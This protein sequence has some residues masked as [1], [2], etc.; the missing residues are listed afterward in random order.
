MDKMKEFFTEI[1]NDKRKRFIS[2]GIISGVVLIILIIIIAVAASGGSSSEDSKGKSSGG[3]SEDESASSEDY[4]KP[5]CS[6]ACSNPYNIKVYSDNKI[7]S[8]LIKCGYK[9]NTDLFN[10]VLEAT[11]RHNILRACHNAQPLLPNCEIMKISQDYAETLPYTHSGTKFHG[12]WMGENLFGSWGYNLNGAFPVNDWYNEISNYDF[13]TGTKKNSGDIGHFTQLVWK[14]SR[15]LGIGYYCQS[16]Q[17][18]V[19]GNYYP[20]GNIGGQYTSQ[21]QALQ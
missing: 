7:T 17:C 2:I 4:I 15:D 5:D 9:K 3:N 18:V 21:V 12:E 10:F 13:S 20:G 11:K 16:S 8:Q 14:N 1:W 19:V 6:G